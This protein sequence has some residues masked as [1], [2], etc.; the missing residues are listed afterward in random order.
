MTESSYSLRTGGGDRAGRR[1]DKGTR[2]L[3]K[4][5]MF[6]YFDCSNACTWVCMSKWIK[7]Y[8]LNMCNLLHINYTS[9][10]LFF[11]KHFW[12]MGLCS[13]FEG[14]DLSTWAQPAV[15]TMEPHTTA[16]GEVA[17][18][19]SQQIS[20]LLV[21]QVAGEDDQGGDKGRWA[22]ARRVREISKHLLITWWSFGQHN[23]EK[24]L[25]IKGL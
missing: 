8:P 9:I 12:H 10:K 4:W 6:S 17:E 13:L 21:D 16:G 20:S 1:A 11:K 3:W 7:V 23:E 2:K 18:L 24:L 15:L 19:L 5:W 22:G 14:P 25:L